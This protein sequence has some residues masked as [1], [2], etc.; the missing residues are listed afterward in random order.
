MNSKDVL[1]EIASIINLIIED[2]EWV[3]QHESDKSGNIDQALT[4]L[5]M[6]HFNF[7]HHYLGG[8]ID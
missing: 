1:N 8:K 5:S 6:L 2:P 4:K 3:K 7:Y